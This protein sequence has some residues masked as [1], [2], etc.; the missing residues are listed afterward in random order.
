MNITEEKRDEIVAE[1]NTA[2]TDFLNIL[3]Q[4][5]KEHADEIRFEAPV[6]GDLDFSELK[7]Q[8]FKHVRSITFNHPGEVTNIRNIPEGI[9]RISC[10]DQ[11]L[12]EL[13]GLPE[14]IEELN[15]EGNS[16][17]KFDAAGLQK[18]RILQLS[19]N[20]L[21]DLKNLPASLEELLCDNNLLSS[22][23]LA[24]ATELH[25]LHCSNNHLLVIANP[26]PSLV[27]F[28]MNDNPLTTITREKEPEREKKIDYMEAMYNYFQLKRKYETKV[29]GM[30]TL[31]YK[32]KSGNKK[33]GR[34]NARLVRPPCVNCHR[35]VGTIFDRKKNRYTAVCG[36]KGHPCNL[37]IQLFNG[38]FFNTD[39]LLSI[40]GDELNVIKE[41]IIKQKMNTLFSYVNEDKTVND[42]KSE[43]DKYNSDSKMYKDLLNKHK[44]LYNNEEERLQISKK[45]AEIYEI[46]A[47]IDVQMKEY[48]KSRNLDALGTAMHIQKRDLIPAMQSLRMK[49]WGL[50]EVDISPENNVSKLIQLEVPL[51]KAE[52]T[53][54]E[55][56]RV[57]KYTF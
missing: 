53:Y 35:P 13:K 33:A 24:N 17:S 23:D 34:K 54:G 57:V 15:I 14:T 30:K 16:L 22:I 51:H 4:L 29:K 43:L 32:L 46:I 40:Y 37:N 5:N 50:M 38:Y 12:I 39:L 44:E 42:F 41:N 36:D 45:T 6:H 52:F 48:E 25:T 11:M 8:G 2:Q 31:E 21:T 26:P 27:D 7:D 28:K 10:P 20:E 18:L 3:K 9:T 19:N 47:E 56:A 55:P 1:N 49:K